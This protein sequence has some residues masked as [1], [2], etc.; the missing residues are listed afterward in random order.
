MLCSLLCSRWTHFKVMDDK[1]MENTFLC[2]FV[3][4][5]STAP[6]SWS[7]A[8]PT[9]SWRKARRTSG[10]RTPECAWC[11]GWPFLSRTVRCCG[12]RRLLSPSSAVSRRTFALI[13][14]LV[15]RQLLTWWL[16]C[17]PAVGPGASAGGELLPHQLLSGGR[18]RA[19]HLWVQHGRSV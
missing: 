6:A 1:L 14:L 10:G 2:I 3:I 17:S 12:C 16:F 8:T 4:K 11:S 13:V 15:K 19:A 9:S 5:A 18:R 7:Y